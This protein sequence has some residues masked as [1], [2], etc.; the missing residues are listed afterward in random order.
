MVKG[1]SVGPSEKKHDGLLAPHNAGRYI[2]NFLEAGLIL[3]RV[4][5]L[6][7]LKVFFIHKILCGVFVAALVVVA[8]PVYCVVGIAHGRLLA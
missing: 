1:L 3:K 6:H 4:E 7:A 2:K 5:G 8:I